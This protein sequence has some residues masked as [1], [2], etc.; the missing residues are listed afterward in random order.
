MAQVAAAQV[1]MAQVAA[2]GDRSERGKVLGEQALPASYH[3]S[4]QIPH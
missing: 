3:S 2:A 1:V 4:L